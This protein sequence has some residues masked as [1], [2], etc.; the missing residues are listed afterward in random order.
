M[1]HGHA[2]L[3][4]F[5]PWVWAGPRPETCGP[6]LGLNSSLWAWAGLDLTNFCG[7]GPGLDSNCGPGLGSNNMPS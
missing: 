1:G 2:G 4:V 6:G 3:P 7:P 5:G